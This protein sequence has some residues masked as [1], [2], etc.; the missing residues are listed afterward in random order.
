MGDAMDSAARAAPLVLASASPR[1]LDLLRRV[2]LEPTTV[3]P[4]DVDETPLPR[5]LPGPHALR[6]AEAKAR[7]VMVAHAAAWIVAADTVV[8]CGRRI[9]PK[10]ATEKEAR[11]CLALLSGRRH[12]VH[13]GVCVVDPAGRVRARRV[14]TTVAFK[15]LT[16]REIA[17]YIGSGEWRDKAGGYAIQGRAGAFVTSI[18]GSYFNVVGLPL[19]ETLTLLEGMGFVRCSAATRD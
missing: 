15:R 17:A 13:G 4:A 11:A 19:Y 1:R 12:R 5:E 9:L 3:A 2:G 6:L 10:P 8:A 14:V 18:V 7:A 16:A